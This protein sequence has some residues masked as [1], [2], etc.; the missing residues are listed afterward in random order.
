MTRG[1]RLGVAWSL[2]LGAMLLVLAGGGEAAPRVAS[3][4]ACTDQLLLRLADPGQIASVSEYAGNPA[5]SYMAGAAARY[6]KNHGHAEEI[7][8][9]GPD[10]VLSGPYTNRASKRRLRAL[11]FRVVELASPDGFAGIRANIRQVA[12]IVGHP[13]RGERLIAGMD[14]ILGAVRRR[15]PPPGERLRVLA[16][17]PN[18]VTVGRGALLDTLMRAAGLRNAGRELGA[19]VY[20]EVPLEELVATAPDMIILAAFSGAPPSLA[21]GV[22]QHPV[23]RALDTKRSPMWLPGRLWSCGGWFA[24]EAVARMAKHAYGI[25]VPA[26]G[27][28][29]ERGGR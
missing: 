3:M 22:L 4:N 11:G 23:F 18:G 26:G 21:Q 25:R 12:R 5:F 2:V 14:R 16:L 10:V 7:L 9:R 19:G 13:A 27:E 17:R 1:G 6:P 20:D 8:A 24:G 15:L 28:G 29:S